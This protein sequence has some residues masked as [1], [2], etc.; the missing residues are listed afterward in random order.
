[1]EPKVAVFVPT[2]RRPDRLIQ[3]LESLANQQIDEPFL[4]T[5][6][7]N[8]ADSLEGQAAAKSWAEA[9]GFVERLATVVVPERGISQ[10]RNKGLSSIIS[11]Y[12]SVL[13]I[14]M[15]DDDA[16]AGSTWL[17]N[18]IAV[19]YEFR[20]DL[21]GGPVIYRFPGDSPEWLRSAPTFRTAEYQTGFVKRLRGSGNCLITSALLQKV[22]PRPF[23]DAFGLTGS[24]DV[25]FFE[26]CARLGAVSAWAADA[27]VF[28]MV[29]LERISRDW[30]LKKMH[31]VGF[32]DVMI[33]MK[34][35]PKFYVYLSQ[36]ILITRG[37]VFGL[38]RSLAFSDRTLRL[39]GE[40]R[41]AQ[42]LGR[43]AALRKKQIA[44]Y[45]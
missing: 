33:S 9:R 44:F 28:E 32:S 36:L 7:D 15:I 19:Q 1:M 30:I 14:A 18:L 12:P 13:L 27:L 40:I 41:I 38:V 26:R 23:D 22:M 43:V 34:Y 2:F 5:V 37:L 21:V 35:G 42:S 20:A 45:R 24:E 10:C 11:M 8:D 31:S 29:P 3:T 39:A 6:A 16:Q 25:D 4:I 17:R